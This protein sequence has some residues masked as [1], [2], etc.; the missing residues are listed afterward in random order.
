MVVGKTIAVYCE[1]HSS[2][3]NTLR[4]QNAEFLA[5]S[6]VGTVTVANSCIRSLDF[7]SKQ[8][9]QHLGATRTV[10]WSDTVSMNTLCDINVA[11]D[12]E[13][14]AS[15]IADDST[16]NEDTERKP[17]GYHHSDHDPRKI[18]DC[19]SGTLFSVEAQKHTTRQAVHT[20]FTTAFCTCKVS[21]GFTMY[22]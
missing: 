7:S 1:T 9:C 18:P 20:D 10:F 16:R 17:W 2:N 3:I 8:G 4:G 6:V 13:S 19:I 5:T 12:F 21:H 14:P 22:V 15:F 11:S